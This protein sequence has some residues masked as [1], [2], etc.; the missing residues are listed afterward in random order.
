MQKESSYVTVTAQVVPAHLRQILVY[1]SICAKQIA[2]GLRRVSL[3]KAFDLH[4]I[5][6]LDLGDRVSRRYCR[7]YP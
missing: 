3:A 5:G 4:L 7:D 2:T 1:S 6:F